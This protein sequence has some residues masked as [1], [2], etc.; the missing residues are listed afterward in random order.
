MSDFLFREDLYSL[1]YVFLELVFGSFCEDKSKRPDQNA[2]KRLLED[3]FKGDFKAFKV[4]GMGGAGAAR[5]GCGNIEIE[6][7]IA[8]IIIKVMK[9]TQNLLY[10]SAMKL[11]PVT[12]VT[13]TPVASCALWSP[14]QLCSAVAPC[15]AG[16][17]PT[18]APCP[19][20]LLPV[21][22]NYCTSLCTP[23]PLP[24]DVQPNLSDPSNRIER[25]TA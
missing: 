6:I 19:S 4:V 23:P 13:L 21:Y 17:S 20:S 25:T 11:H 24:V 15:T 1:G 7:A 3:I 10:L 12:P 22:P 18:L 14:C 5:I 8:N 9:Q 2:L 16:P